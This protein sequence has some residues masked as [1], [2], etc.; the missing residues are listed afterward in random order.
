MR[1]R[2]HQSSSISGRSSDRNEKKN[3]SEFFDIQAAQLIRTLR[4][5]KT[6]Q[7]SPVRLKSR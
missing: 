5:R 7:S 6:H 1:R 4:R 3:S 2:T